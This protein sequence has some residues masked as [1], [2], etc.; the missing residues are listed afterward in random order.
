MS[1]Q[2]LNYECPAPE[3]P[4]SGRCLE[5]DPGRLPRLS[6][7][8]ALAIHLEGLVQSGNVADYAEIA[9]LGH[10]TRARVSQIINLLQLAPDIQEEILFMPP[11]LEARDPIG[12]HQV[13][14]IAMVL[15]WP[16]QRHLWQTLKTKVARSS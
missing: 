2:P 6:R 8:L 11:T 5:S 3:L 1:K 14:P 12:L 10:V 16:K 15:S 9:R 13:Q 4:A 7:L